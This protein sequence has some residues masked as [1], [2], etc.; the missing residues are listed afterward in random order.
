M[1]FTVNGDIN[2]PTTTQTIAPNSSYTVDVWA[3]LQE[4]ED[5]P[6]TGGVANLGYTF[7]YFGTAPRAPARSPAGPT[8]LRAATAVGITAVNATTGFTKTAISPGDWNSDGAG[9]I[10]SLNRTR[11]R[12]S[13]S[14]SSTTNYFGNTGSDGN[15]GEAVGTTGWAWEIGTMTV[16]TGATIGAAGT[17]TIFTRDPDVHGRTG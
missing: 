9:D 6:G 13:T 12:R 3:V 8:A 7:T 10:S 1:D 2:S 14:T 16:T 4:G 15:L 11:T 5:S 17:N